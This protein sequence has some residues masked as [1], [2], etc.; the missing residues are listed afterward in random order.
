MA[1]ATRRLLTAEEFGRLPDNDLVEELARGKIVASPLP[2]FAHGFA[3]AAIGCRLASFLEERDIGH[4]LARS[5]V[6]TQRDPDTVC[7]PDAT[8]YSCD[9]LPKGPLSSDYGP[10][11]PE[12]VFEVLSSSDR[13]PDLLEKVAEYLNAGSLAAAVLDPKARAA[14]VYRSE[15]PP[16][17]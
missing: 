6:I 13:W 3:C 11:I 1:T 9:K 8:Y 2:G 12:L 16:V 10:E 14:H 4:A 5:A 15:T 17:T 7:G